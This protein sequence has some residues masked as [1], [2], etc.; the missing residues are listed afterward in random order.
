[1]QTSSIR[2]NKSWLK[3]FDGYRIKRG[4]HAEE[5]AKGKNIGTKLRTPS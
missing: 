5:Q 3:K 4:K 1:L 2:N